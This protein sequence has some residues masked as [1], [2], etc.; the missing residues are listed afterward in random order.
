MKLEPDEVEFLAQVPLL[1]ADVAS[2]AEDPAAA[3]LE[4]P[5]YLDDPEAN[6]DWWRLMKGE[7]VSS[8]NADRSAFALLVEA[9]A[10]GTVASRLEAEAFLR[11][12]VEGRLAL[13]ARLGVDTD[14]DYEKL[15]PADLGALDYLAQMQVLLLACL[16]LPDA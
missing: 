13:G 6:T 2:F 7:L 15:D 8:R 14:D 1:L 9:A 16:D 11:V 12:L 5:V 4:V 3:R 10:E